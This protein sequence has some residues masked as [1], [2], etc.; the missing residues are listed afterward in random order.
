VIQRLTKMQEEES[1]FTLVELLVVIVILGILAAIVVFAV[2]GIQD[3]GTNAANQTD[4]SVIQAGEEAYYA[5][6]TSYATIQQLEGGGFLRTASTK[7]YVCLEVTPTANADYFVVTG[8]P[9][10]A[11]SPNPTCVTQAAA[12]V[13]AKVVGTWTASTGSTTYP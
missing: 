12:Q 11:A 1:G 4:V 5:K 6:N 3:K 2:G 8:A 7:S 9:T 10:G 13:P